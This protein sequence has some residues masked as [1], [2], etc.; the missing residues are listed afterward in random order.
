MKL[1]DI[2]NLFNKETSIDI[3]DKNGK[4]LAYLYDMSEIIFCE[5]YLEEEIKFICASCEDVITICLKNY[6]K[7]D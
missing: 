7:V 6:E 1:K 3:I 5:E 4:R 2:Q